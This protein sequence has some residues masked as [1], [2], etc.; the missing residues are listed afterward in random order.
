MSYNLY[1]VPYKKIKSEW[2]IYLNVKPKTIK[3][4]GESLCNLGL[5][6]DFLHITT[7]AQHIKAQ[8]DKMGFIKM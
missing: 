2:I 5:G 3:L 4:P 8:I 7:N 6:K 1:L